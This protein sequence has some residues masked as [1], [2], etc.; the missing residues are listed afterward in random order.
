EPNANARAARRVTRPGSSRL[1]EAE[2]IFATVSSCMAP[3]PVSFFVTRF[4][5][6][7]RSQVTVPAESDRSRHSWS[8]C[9][10]ERPAQASLL[11]QRYH[12]PDHSPELILVVNEGHVQ[13]VDARFRQVDHAVDH[14]LGRPDQD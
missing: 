1:P 2:G 14:L 7:S 11:H 8:A 9:G 4:Y 6:R 12:L 5:A 10:S 3:F 13:T